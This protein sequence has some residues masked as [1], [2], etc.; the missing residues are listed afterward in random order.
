MAKQVLDVHPGKGMTVS[1]SNEHLRVAFRGAYLAK[2]SGNFDPTRERLNFEVKKGGIVAPLDK[3]TSIPKRIK[4]NLRKRKIKDP[5]AGLPEGRYRTVANIIIGGS[6]DQMHRLAFGDQK[7]NL[8]YKA[9]NSK[10]IRMPDIERWAVDMYKFMSNRFGEENIAA[11]IVHL[12]ETNPHIHCTLLPVVDNKLSWRKFWVG[13]INTKDAYR[14]A[15]LKL[16][17]ELSDVNKKYGLERGDDVVRTGA[18]HRTLAQYRAEMSAVMKDDIVKMSEQIASWRKEIGQLSEESVMLASEISKKKEKKTQLE[19][20]IIHSTARVRSLSTMIDNL[21]KR[22]NELK[23]E[24]LKLRRDIALGRVTQE[25]YEKKCSILQGEIKKGQ[26]DIEDKIS[27]LMEA[28]EKLG[29]VQRELESKEKQLSGVKSQLHGEKTNL[30]RAA[31]MKGQALLYTASTLNIKS[32][33]QEYRQNLASLSHDQRMFVERVNSPLF[34]DNSAITEMA[35]DGIQVAQ[36]ATNLF[37]GYLDN[38]TA[39]SKSGGGGGGPTGGWGKRDDEDE[40][41]F[42][43]RCFSMARQMRRSGPK[44]KR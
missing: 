14:S 21:L 2:L 24:L 3:V 13:D 22:Q 1:Q 38:A 15:M 40:Y 27:K 10:I 17:D 35:D 7:V 19:R 26:V 33:M 18:K 5:N 28:Q 6:R 23:D 20:E 9:D 44:R 25:E 4:E 29:N 8:D 41:A 11:F 42:W 36:I 12:D 30:N 37:L 39:I 43:N 31:F 16:H 34:S 32:K